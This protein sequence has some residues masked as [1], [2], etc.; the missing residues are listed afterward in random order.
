[1]ISS[2]V[3]VMFC[4]APIRLMR[5]FMVSDL[6]SIKSSGCPKI[7]LITLSMVVLPVPD[8]SL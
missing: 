6:I 7:L 1:M 2:I 5:E 8:P 3:G 4:M